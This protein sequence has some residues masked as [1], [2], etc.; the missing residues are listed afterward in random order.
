MKRY[1]IYFEFYGRKMSTTLMAEDEF[2]A[3]NQVRNRINF[4][5]VETLNEDFLNHFKD[6]FK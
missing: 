3:K 1:K 6:I 2:K 5:K 4:I